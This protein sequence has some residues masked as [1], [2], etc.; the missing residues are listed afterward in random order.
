MKHLRI[1]LLENASEQGTVADAF[2]STE[3]SYSA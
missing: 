2:D 3:I 1:R